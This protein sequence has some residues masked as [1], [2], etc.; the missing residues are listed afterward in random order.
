MPA[1]V[2]TLS[3][4]IQQVSGESSS[5]AGEMENDGDISDRRCAGTGL[6]GV[7][8]RV[9]GGLI[10]NGSPRVQQSL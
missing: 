10:V 4:P 7:C 6:K 5:N 2:I 1:E 9:T 3:T 8:D